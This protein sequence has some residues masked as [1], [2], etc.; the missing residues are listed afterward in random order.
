MFMPQQLII[1]SDFWPD[2]D[3]VPRLMGVVERAVPL[4]VRPRRGYGRSANNL[5]PPVHQRDARGDLAGPSALQN[6]LA[7]ARDN[8]RCADKRI[9]DLE[10]E[11]A[12]SILS[13][14]RPEPRRRVGFWSPP[15][16]QRCP[17]SLA[18]R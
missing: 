15:E 1:Y 4:W 6:K 3:I 10:V 14:S 17:P 2:A 12:A 5:T 18:S 9:A 16:R 11:C 8:V 7:A 13:G